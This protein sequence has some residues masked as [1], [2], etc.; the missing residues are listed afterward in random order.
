MLRRR[1]P[2]WSNAD[3]LGTAFTFRLVMADLDFNG[4]AEEIVGFNRWW[5]V[6]KDSLSERV[7][8]GV[9]MQACRVP[10]EL[11]GTAIKREYDLQFMTLLSGFEPVFE[12]A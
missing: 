4:A 5:H 8:I 6:A 10:C 11:R 1:R 2:E 7:E 3:N 9:R 12:D